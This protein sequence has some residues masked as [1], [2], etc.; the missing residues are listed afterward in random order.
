LRIGSQTRAF[1]Q[2]IDKV[3]ML[4]LTALKGGSKSEFVIFVNKIQVQ[5]KKVCYKVSLCKKF[6]RQSCSWTI[7]LSNSVYMLG[8]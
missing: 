4:P 7:S 3:R 1:E 2:A 6:R 5:L 8:V